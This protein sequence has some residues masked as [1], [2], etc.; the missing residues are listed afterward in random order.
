MSIITF[1]KPPL[2]AW[3]E[4]SCRKA[5]GKSAKIPTIMRIDIPLP[6]P[7]SV[8]FSPN[9]IANKDPATRITILGNQ[10]INELGST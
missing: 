7:L 3:V 6:I 8:I 2:P 5:E 9:H 1:P 10:N 4:T